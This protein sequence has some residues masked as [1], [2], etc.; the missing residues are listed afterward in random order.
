MITEKFIEK[1]FPKG[2]LTLLGG[3]PAVGKSSFAVSISISLARQNRKCIY[4]SS[5]FEER[6]LTERYKRQV[7]IEEY[8]SIVGN[9][10]VDYNT[11]AINTNY[12]RKIVEHYQPDYIIMDCIHLMTSNNPSSDRHSEMQD[13]VRELKA[14]A[15]DCNISVIGLIT[16]NRS[17]K[18]KDSYFS[19]PD[20]FRELQL[21][22]LEDIN[23][24]CIHRDSDIINIRK[25]QCEN[26]CPSYSTIVK[27][28]TYH[29]IN[30]E[31]TDLLFNHDTI[32]FSML[33]CVVY[34]HGLS[35]SGA[36]STADSLR[37]LL[38]EY[39]V[40][41]P[42]LPVQPQEA[43]TMLKDLCELRNPELIIGTSMGGMFAQQLRGYKKILV[44]PAFHVS[45]FM[46]TQLG[47]HDFLN[48]RKNGETK[49]EITLDL[50]DSYKAVEADQFADITAYD[51]TNTY[52]LFGS[53][54]TL[55]H[56]FEEYIA[57]YRNAMWFEG[58]HLLNFEIIKN[59]VVPLAKI[60]M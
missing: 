28:V 59:I 52:A 47:V 21:G 57:Y 12:I 16:L 9:I 19:N 41:S 31:I 48:P 29:N 17:C 1:N 2:K 10:I 30:P 34:V 44:N 8:N 32:G 3:C 51:I 60:I 35:S 49:Y 36:S 38:P 11:E 14:L 56:G 37:K 26:E 4:L 46:R 18:S 42:D 53:R 6:V 13:I 55:V 33:P 22:D 27:F 5:K 7:I 50:C 40:L 25:Y 54:D 39:E 24:T 23:L 20:I 15:S 58:E 45:E 43:L